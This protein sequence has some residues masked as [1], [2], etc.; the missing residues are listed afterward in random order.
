ML[1][2][3]INSIFLYFLVPPY[4]GLILLFTFYYV[5]ADFYASTVAYYSIITLPLLFIALFCPLRMELP[6]Y[7]A[8]INQK[9]H[10]YIIFLLCLIIFLCSPLDIA[11]NGFK[12]LH[13]ETYAIYYGLGRYVR[14]ITTLCW[15]F[16]PVAFIFAHKPW[17]KGLLCAYALIFP[18][19]IIDRN[20]LF[21]S[22]Y[23]LFLCYALNYLITKEKKLS[24]TFIFALIPILGF[25]IFCA[26]GFFRS[27]D[28]L[29]IDSSNQELF[30]GTYPLK[31]YMFQMS[32]SL[33][34]VILYLTSPIL[35]FTSVA[36]AH[37][38]NPDFLISQFSPFNRETFDLQPYPPILVGRY[39]V[40]TEFYSFLLY[41]G[42]TFVTGAY[43]FLV[44]GFIASLYLLRNYP[45]IFTFLI[46]IKISYC[47]LFMNFAPQ[48]YILLNFIFFLLMLFLWFTAEL[49]N[50]LQVSIQKNFL[51]NS[52]LL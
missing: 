22:G 48:Y 13:P 34:Q 49:L 32:S 42:L 3:M 41:G 51:A 28:I 40:G 47:A 2:R 44:F 14:H 36:T 37:F 7:Y 35:N 27:S 43:L 15:I 4:I 21:L 45:N 9:S 30:P 50:S 46:F 18:I 17:L 1:K 31:D 39:N 25:L 8:K 26:I 16:V 10:K 19:L 20:R 38:L 11:I 33:Q 5:P 6:K 24:A 23:S 52:Q 29:V 12:L